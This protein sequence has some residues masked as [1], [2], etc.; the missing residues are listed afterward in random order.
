ML[1]AHSHTNTLFTD[2]SKWFSGRF[3]QTGCSAQGRNRLKAERQPWSKLDRE[4]PFVP[5]E[6]FG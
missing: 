4:L 1:S 5:F 6:Q 2:Q 3:Q